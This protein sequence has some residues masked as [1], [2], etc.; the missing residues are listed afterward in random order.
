MTIQISY[1]DGK[2]WAH[3]REVRSD[4][5]AYSDMV[6]HQDGTIGLIYEGVNYGHIF[7]VQ[8]NKDWIIK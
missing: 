3:K 5:S 6:F 8:L 1:D 4:F 2:T 7:Y